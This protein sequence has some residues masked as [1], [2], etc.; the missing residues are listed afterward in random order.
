MESKQTNQAHT[1]NLSCFCKIPVENGFIE[2]QGTIIEV[3]ANAVRLQLSY[4]PAK[5]DV[6]FLRPNYIFDELGST[7]PVRVK[8]LNDISHAEYL[9]EVECEITNFDLDL[10]LHVSRKFINQ[11]KRGF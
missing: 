5:S 4:R 11:N 6:I 1:E 2:V 10:M 8:M 9:C 7:I 3:E